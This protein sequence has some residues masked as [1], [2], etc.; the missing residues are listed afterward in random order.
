M[1]STSQKTFF[2]PHLYIPSGCRDISFYIDGLGATELRRFSN[3]DGTI[4]V[5]ELSI[6]GN[7]FHLHEEK[8]TGGQLD[9]IKAK[10]VTSLVGLFIEDVDGVIERAL[11]AGATLVEAPQSFDYG[12]RQGIIKDPFGHMWLIQK[13][14]P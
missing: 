14:I 7:I 3:D 8:P 13:K 9:P 6:D 12:Y 2:A 5:A 10:G 11:A 4:H 1:S